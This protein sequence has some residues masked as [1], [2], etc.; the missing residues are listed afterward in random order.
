VGSGELCHLSCNQSVHNFDMDLAA[1][2][3]TNYQCTFTVATLLLATVL[4]SD[5]LFELC[6]LEPGRRKT[7]THG[8]LVGLRYGSLT[9]NCL[10]KYLV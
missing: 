4:F 3:G 8:P 5:V 9:A 10:Q 6:R 7:S 2:E 1:L